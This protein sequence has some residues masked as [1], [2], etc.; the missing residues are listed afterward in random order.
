MGYF[1]LAF[2]IFRRN[3]RRDKKTINNIDF[4][5]G[6][7]TLYII[8]NV[9]QKDVD[10]VGITRE[11]RRIDP[12]TGEI[13]HGMKV[14]PNKYLFQ[15]DGYIDGYSQLIQTVEDM[16]IA[17]GVTNY[18]VTRADIRVDSYDI[19]FAKLYKLNSAVVNILASCHD[20]NDCY[21]SM[22]NG[23]I[24]NIV[25]RNTGVEIECYDRIEKDGAGIAKTRLEFRTK[26]RDRNAINTEDLRGVVRYWKELITSPPLPLLYRQFQEK[27]NQRIAEEHRENVGSNSVART[28]LQNSNGIYTSRQMTELCQRLGCNRETAYK[29]K[30]R[31]HVEYHSWNDVNGYLSAIAQSLENFIGK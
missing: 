30:R 20:I 1:V 13:T 4:H 23:K 8:G 29:Y 28:I 27:Q 12:Q 26:Y 10:I 15:D 19:E 25:A 24:H 5:A 22:R 16:M 3:E 18:K 2:F 17:R 9:P 14:N 31:A 7:H 11:N 6:V 21:Q